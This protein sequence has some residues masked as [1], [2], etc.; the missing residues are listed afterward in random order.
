[1]DTDDKAGRGQHNPELSKNLECFI[2]F[3]FRAEMKN[4]PPF[5]K[6]I[7]ICKVEGLKVVFSL[8]CCPAAPPPP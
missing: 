1:M 3:R 7:K 6:S 2:F 4:L 8:L 5:H